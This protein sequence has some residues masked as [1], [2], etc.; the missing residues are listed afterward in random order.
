MYFSIFFDSTGRRIE[1]CKSLAP[2]LHFALLFCAFFI[3]ICSFSPFSEGTLPLYFGK[4]VVIGCDC[5]ILL[6]F[7][8]AAIYPNADYKNQLFMRKIKES[9][10]YIAELIYCL[11][12]AI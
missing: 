3:N 5:F 2:G 6:S 12:K 11:V 9:L 1:G 4:D 8:P 10:A 7:V